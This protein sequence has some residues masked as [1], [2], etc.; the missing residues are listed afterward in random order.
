[1]YPGEF[2]TPEPPGKSWV[3]L[4]CP[5]ILPFAHPC[6]LAS[7]PGAGLPPWAPTSPLPG[8][9]AYT[10]LPCRLAQ[11]RTNPQVLDTGLTAQDIHYAQCLS[12]VDWN[13]ADSGGA[14]PDDLFNF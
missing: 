3:F 13:K 8:P 9:P 12:P 2:L 7:D 4:L 5:R 10:A 14:E 6:S 1:M 11:S